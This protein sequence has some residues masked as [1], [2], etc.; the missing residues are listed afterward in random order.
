MVVDGF[1]A[2]TEFY[3]ELYWDLKKKEKHE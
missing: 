2:G 1:N 3:K